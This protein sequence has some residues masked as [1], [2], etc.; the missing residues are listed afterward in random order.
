[1]STTERDKL[2]REARDSAISRGHT[3]SHF[4]NL[5]SGTA[6][7]NCRKCDTIAVVRVRPMP[8][9]IDITC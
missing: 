2:K 4:E 7:A 5:P 9:E 3:M 8:N 6:I 1:M